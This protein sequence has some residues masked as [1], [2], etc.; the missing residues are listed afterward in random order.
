MRL[1]DRFVLPRLIHLACGIR[2]VQ[3]QRMKIVPLAA[4]DVLEIGFGSGLNLPQYESAAVR[5][6]WALEPSEEMWRLA[7]KAVSASPLD[8]EFLQAPAEAIP[9][10]D[11]SM[12][13]V[14]VTYALCTIPDVTRALQEMRRVLKPEGK[15]LF[16]EHGA[17][18][19]PNVR[20]WQDRLNPLWKRLA[21]GC[22]L[23]RPIP[24]LIQSAGF[25]IDRLSTMYLP[26]WKPGTFNY[27]G[28][29]TTST[30]FSS[31]SS[32]PAGINELNGGEG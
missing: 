22:N 21:G 32:H 3:L 23:N 1:Y 26:G 29:A 17:A 30:A 24:T 19:D 10:P 5:R 7:Q 8:V 16:C 13:T 14:L 20:R 2:P 9:L 11:A 18:P 6:I 4:G 27:W 25:H 15:L 31:S 28:T 12:D